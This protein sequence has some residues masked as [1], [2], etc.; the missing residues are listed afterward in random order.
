MRYIIRLSYDG[1]A[2]CGWQVQPSAVTVQGEVERCLSTLLG[3]SIS[4]TGAG[5]TDTGVNAVNYVLHFDVEEKLPMEPEQLAYK[6]NAIL[7]LKIVVHELVPAPVIP[8]PEDGSFSQDWHARYSAVC[9]EYHYFIHQGKDPFEKKIN[10]PAITP[11]FTNRDTSSAFLRTMQ[12]EIAAVKPIEPV[13][14]DFDKDMSVLKAK[15]GIEILYKQN[16]TSDLYEFTIS[17]ETGSF[18]D[19][20]LPFACKY[21]NYVGTSTMSSDQI[22]AEFYKDGVKFMIGCDEENTAVMMVG[23]GEYMKNAIRTMESLIADAQANPE[24]LDLMKENHIGGIPVVDGI[25]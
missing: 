21:L 2:Y 3:T 9:R 16:M 8:R 13:F 15:S 23:L 1:S 12:A 14:V 17:L 4:V 24:A 19:K 5:R 22:V 25:Q 7:P 20:I 10:K 11:I 18:A 6:L